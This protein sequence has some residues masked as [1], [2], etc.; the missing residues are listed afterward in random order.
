MEKSIETDVVPAG[1]N[2]E[3]DSRVVFI[4]GRQIILD[5][6]LA[7]VDGVPTKAL[8]QVGRSHGCL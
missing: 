7:E 1:G 8:N 6:S 4:R 5:S 3:V 2:P